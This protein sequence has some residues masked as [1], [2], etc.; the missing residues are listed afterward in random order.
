MPGLE[1]LGLSAEELESVSQETRDNLVMMQGKL[2]ADKQ[3]AM[4]EVLREDQE[5]LDRRSRRVE[6]QILG[7]DAN[8]CDDTP[9]DEHYRYPKR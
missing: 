5:A 6:N 9:V 2:I 8:K 3:M 4:T 7:R 1:E